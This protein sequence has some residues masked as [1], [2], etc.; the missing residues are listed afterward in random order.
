M[1]SYGPEN[2]YG[3]EPAKDVPPDICV[4]AGFHIAVGHRR[5]DANAIHKKNTKD[6][7]Q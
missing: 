4:N 7:Y 5:E 2:K 1:I 3:V 6:S